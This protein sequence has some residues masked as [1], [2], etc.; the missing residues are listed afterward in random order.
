[1]GRPAKDSIPTRLR[2]LRRLM[3]ERKVDVLLV[4]SVDEHQNEYPPDPHKRRQAVTGFSGS[5]GD[6]A[7]CA[8]EAHL[9][10]DSRYHLQADQE[11]DAKLFR[12]H[13]MGLA[14]ETDLFGWLSG[15]EA[16][17][18]PLRVGFDPFL[19]SGALHD[20]LA[21]TLIRPRSKLVPLSPNPVD[22][23]WKERPQPLCRPVYSLPDEVTGEP[24]GEKLARLRKKLAEAGAEAILLTKLDEVAWLTNL[25]GSEVPFNPVFEAYLTVEPE[26][27]DCYTDSPI[28]YPVLAGLEGLVRFHP[29]RDFPKGLRGLARRLGR[30][31]GKAGGKRG[32]KNGGKLWLDEASASQ[33]SRALARAAESLAVAPNPVARMKALKNPV[34]LERIMEGHL[35]A[36]CAKVRAFSRLGAMLAEG[37]RVSEAGFAD[38]LYEE[39]AREADFKELSFTTISA[40]GANGAIVHYGTPDP[41]KFLEPG[42]MLLVDSGVQFLGATTDDTRTIAIG[43]P[44]ARHRERYTD[45]LRAHIRL[46]LQVFPEGTTGVMLD[47]I[48]RSP[49]WNVGADYGHGTGHGVGAFLNVH[50]GPQSISSRGTEP[51]EPGMIVSNEPGYYRAGWGGIRLEN[52]YAVE[53]MLG[54]PDHPAGKRWLRFVPLTFIPFDLSLIEWERLTAEEQAWLTHYHRLVA[55]NLAPHLA[56]ADRRWLERACGGGS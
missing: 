12:L 10:V 35:K 24:A 25:R 51:L 17:H 27:A 56:E 44:E 53:E 21:R 22:E 3:A 45:V 36:G 32:G 41:R 11:V 26:G 29:T 52:L 4:P 46:A 54:L 42:G 18:G 38:L 40:F 48:A 28:P 13:K 55:E 9:F 5:A 34:E 31:G 1:M 37:K 7:I 15:F 20:R 30:D 14:G 8:R 23:V 6:A 43:T 49:L 2:A 16:E 19:M 47:A 39:Y 50:E 33:G